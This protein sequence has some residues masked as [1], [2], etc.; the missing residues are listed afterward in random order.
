MIFTKWGYVSKEP[1]MV[2]LEFGLAPP[3]P[4]GGSLGY[5]WFSPVIA[6]G[7][8]IFM[9]NEYIMYCAVKIGS[10]PPPCWNQPVSASLLYI[11]LLLK[12]QKIAYR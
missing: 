2:F 8:V 7:C 5:V 6:Q 11:F 1:D 4:G 10:S 12:P 3:S 9:V